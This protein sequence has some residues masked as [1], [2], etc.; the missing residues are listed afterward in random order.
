[1][2]GT[3]GDGESVAVRSAAESAFLKPVAEL[4]I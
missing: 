2:H 4:S 1:M 3:F